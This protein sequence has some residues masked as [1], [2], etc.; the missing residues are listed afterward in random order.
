MRRETEWLTAC[1]DIW[2]PGD[3]VYASGSEVPDKNADFSEERF[4]VVE[5]RSDV[6]L[7]ELASHSLKYG[8]FYES[9]VRHVESREQGRG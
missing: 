2:A 6:L 7:I 9:R 1:P 3:D 5:K 8:E 4:I